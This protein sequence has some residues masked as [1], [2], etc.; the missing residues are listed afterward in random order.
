MITSPAARCRVAGADVDPALGSWDLGSW[1]GLS[2]AA[3]PDLE[4]WRSDP[5]FAGHGGESLLDLQDRVTRWLAGWRER[6]GRWAAVT[7]GAVV[8]AAV[9]S[10]L[11]APPLAVWDLDVSPGS[12]TELHTTR[13][14]WRVVRVGARA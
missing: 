8:A 12:L 7:H 4:R 13:D 14:G 2:V 11:R 9:T 3:L 5:S 6:P 1:T 10:V